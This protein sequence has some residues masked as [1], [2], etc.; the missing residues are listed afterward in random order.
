MTNLEPEVTSIRLEWKD[1]L[2]EAL[3]TQFA[4]WLCD[5]YLSAM[6]YNYLKTKSQNM[7]FMQFCV[8]CVLMLACAQDLKIMKTATNRIST[9]GTS[10]EQKTHYQ[11]KCDK[12]K[13]KYKP[14]Q[15]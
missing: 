2:N 1:E 7:I 14:R 9:S 3:K 12:N 10:E 15:S 6:A 13:E 8:E 5:P 11:I 4:F